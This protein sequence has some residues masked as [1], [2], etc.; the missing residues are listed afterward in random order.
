MSA[1]RHAGAILREH[2][3]GN[4]AQWEKSKGNP[5]TQADL[6]A[7]ELI[8]AMLTLQ[9]PRDGLLT[10]ESVDDLSRLER[11]RCWIIDPMDG[12]REFTEKRPEFSVSIALAIRGRPAVAVVFN[13]MRDVLYHAM[14]GG[15]CF[16]NEVRVQVSPCQRLDQ[17]R[18]LASR[19]ELAQQRLDRVEDWFASLEPMGSIAWKLAL[20]AG[21]EIDFNVSMRPKSEWDVCAGDLLIHEAGGYYVDF[22][23]EPRRYNLRDP[24]EQAPMVAG[25]PALLSEFRDRYASL[26]S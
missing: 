21:G 5:V 14:Q 4:P 24:V 20:V 6:E 13:P 18:V 8:R 23:G 12:T 3:A 15:G 1:A 10:E 9:F 25:N 16:R 11:D 22:A 7:D 17:A 26:E 2:F 19:S